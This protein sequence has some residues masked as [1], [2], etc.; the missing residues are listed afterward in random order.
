MLTTA[1][2]WRGPLVLHSPGTSAGFYRQQLQQQ[3]IDVLYC[4]DDWTINRLLEGDDQSSWPDGGSHSLAVRLARWLVYNRIPLGFAGWPARSPA[5]AVTPS[6]I[7]VSLRLEMVARWRWRWIG[8]AGR[9]SHLPV[10]VVHGKGRPSVRAPDSEQTRQPCSWN[11][12]AS[13]ER[14]I[15]VGKCW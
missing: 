1:D 14:F 13:E 3:C 8:G 6:I 7:D 12:V 2:L 9:A 5:G 15:G 4:R 10:V 11:A